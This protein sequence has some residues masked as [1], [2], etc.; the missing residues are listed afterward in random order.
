MAGGEKAFV[1]AVEGA[2]DKEE[3]GAKRF[4]KNSFE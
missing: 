1:K 2:E 4:T 3:L